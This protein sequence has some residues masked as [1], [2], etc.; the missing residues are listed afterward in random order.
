MYDVTFN[1]NNEKIDV[2]VDDTTMCT[3]SITCLMHRI[4]KLPI[5]NYIEIRTTFKKTMLKLLI[6]VVETLMIF[7]FVILRMCVH[8]YY[9]LYSYFHH[10]CNINI[11]LYVCH[12]NISKSLYY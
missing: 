5:L 6:I 1:N 10:S 2:V 11:C 4:D 3:T 7:Y 12:W 8:G 9:S